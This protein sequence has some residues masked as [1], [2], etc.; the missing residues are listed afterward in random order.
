MSSDSFKII[1]PTNN[2]FANHTY[3]GFGIKYA[4]KHNQPTGQ[5]NQPYFYT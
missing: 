4:K 5:Q 3:E 1:L 2:S